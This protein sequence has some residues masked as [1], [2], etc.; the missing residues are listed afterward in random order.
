MPDWKR[1]NTLDKI[2]PSCINPFLDECFYRREYCPGKGFFFSETN[3][4]IKNFKHNISTRPD[5]ENHKLFSI[6]KFALEL[7]EYFF[8]FQK[9]HLSFIPASKCKTDISY[10]DRLEKTLAGLKR[11]KPNVIIEEPVI[12]EN[13]FRASHLGGPRFMGGK[14]RNYRWQGFSSKTGEIGRLYIIDDV[15][16]TGTHFKAFKNII[17]AHHPGVEV[18]G[19]FW[20][21]T[22]RY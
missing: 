6:N 18:I 14:N 4:L 15:I 10:D 11:L 5:L 8:D 1:I 19:L 2:I 9:F 7:S 21:K 17:T 12:L 3:Q 13:S 22:V 16:T 20:A